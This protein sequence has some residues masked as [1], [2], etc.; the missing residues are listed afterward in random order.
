M[1]E[2]AGAAV[3]A[4]LHGGLPDE[5]VVWEIL[6]RL[7]PKSL[8]RCRAVC[9][10]WRR[11][12]STRDFLLAHHA[13]QPSLPLLCG[14]DIEFAGVSLDVISLDHRAGLGAVDQLQPVARLGNSFFRLRAS[15]DGLLLLSS[16]Y[17]NLGFSI[18]NPAT[19]QYA[20]LPQLDGFAVLGIYPHSPTGEYRLLLAKSDASYVFTLGSDQ[21]PKR[22]WCPDSENTVC[23]LSS[24]LFHGSLHWHEQSG[25]NMVKVFNTTTEL[26]RRMG[27]PSVPGKANLFEMDGMLGMSSFNDA[28]TTIDI[29]TTQDYESEVW[30]IKYRVELPVAQL[31]VKFG[32]FDGK[33]NVVPSR[34][35]DV[36][37]LV[38]FGNWLLQIDM[39]GKLVASFHRVLHCTD[40]LRL[41]QSLVPHSFFPTLEGYVVNDSPF[42]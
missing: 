41:K 28:A 4:H 10:A 29:W 37:M 42:I 2:A 33:W 7:P 40:Q 16:L 8:L 3:P 18:C 36:L 20:R 19:R 38:N 35:V 32:K 14:Y 25:S 39:N 1:A 23:E 22:I 21:P 24:V 26:F 31:T 9:P 12:T 13:R 15:C 17:R 11:A 30:A 5:I 27:A 6:V 34:D